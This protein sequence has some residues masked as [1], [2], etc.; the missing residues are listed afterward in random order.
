MMDNMSSFDGVLDSNHSL[1]SI[2]NFPNR[3]RV[4]WMMRKVLD[5]NRLELSR[6]EK[7]RQKIK[8]SFFGIVRVQEDVLNID[9][10]LMPNV[11]SLIGK[12]TSTHLDNYRFKILYNL[13]RK[14]NMPSLFDF[15]SA[16]KLRIQ[17]LEKEND[18]LKVELNMLK[19]ERGDDAGLRK[20]NKRLCEELQQLKDVSGCGKGI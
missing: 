6:A 15:P 5:I 4:L 1:I 2:G 16:E 13:V 8:I 9:I 18:Q 11:L 17:R 10:K 19:R 12:E 20:E 7:A 14:W 3:Y